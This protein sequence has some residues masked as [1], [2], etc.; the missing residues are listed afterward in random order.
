MWCEIWV[1]SVTHAHL[2]SQ[3][4]NHRYDAFLVS[5]V[6]DIVDIF[7]ESVVVALAEI[8]ALVVGQILHSIGIISLHS[9]KG[10]LEAES[11]C[12]CINLCLAHLRTF[13]KAVKYWYS[14]WDAYAV[15]VVP[16][17]GLC[18]MKPVLEL[19]RE[20]CVH[21][22][23][24]ESQGRQVALLCEL[25]LLVGK[26]HLLLH[27]LQLIHVFVQS[28]HFSSFYFIDAL[29]NDLYL[30][31]CWIV[32]YILQHVVLLCEH[33][34]GIGRLYLC[35]LDANIDALQVNFKSHLVVIECLSNFL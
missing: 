20:G 8:V 21:D 30:F 10:V 31:F 9:L 17:I 11:G 34:Q 35:A 4:L 3:D 7:S 22:I 23:A 16:V 33:S 18:V 13:L 1:L 32:E 14:K 29:G 15:W 24:C 25:C 28:W 12:F 6:S 5:V 19:V 27:K 26:R 2:V